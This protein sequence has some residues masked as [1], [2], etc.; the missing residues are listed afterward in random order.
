M[1]T[2][3]VQGRGSREEV[4]GGALE[5]DPRL[6]DVGDQHPPTGYTVLLGGARVEG[7]CATLWVVVMRRVMMVMMI[8]VNL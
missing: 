6:M 8:M 5:G 1:T 3:G 7:D 4:E 2:A